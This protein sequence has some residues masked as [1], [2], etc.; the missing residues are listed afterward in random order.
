MKIRTELSDL[1]RLL[2]AGQP[3]FRHW[4]DGIWALV[5]DAVAGELLPSYITQ[6]PDL[7]WC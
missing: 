4:D 2:M 3:Q 5:I 1:D 6:D 7:V